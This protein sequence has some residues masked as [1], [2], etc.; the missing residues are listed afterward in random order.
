MAV[1][2]ASLFCLDLPSPAAQAHTV[3]SHPS[4]L[5]ARHAARCMAAASGLKRS[6]VRIGTHSG[7][8]HCD[9]ALGCWLLQ[10]TKQFGGPGASV[11]RSRDPKVWDEQD[12]LIDVG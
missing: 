10:R 9:E 4:K 1:M 7:T 3:V 11:T 6:M 2:A 12:V 5:I 8:F